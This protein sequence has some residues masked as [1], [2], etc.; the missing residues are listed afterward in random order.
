LGYRIGN[1][2]EILSGDSRQKNAVDTPFDGFN[3]IISDNNRRS[4]RYHLEIPD[5]ILLLRQN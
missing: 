1:I 4:Q 5:N 2:W 3:G